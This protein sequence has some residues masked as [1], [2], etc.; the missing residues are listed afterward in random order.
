MTVYTTAFYW[1]VTYFF[2]ALGIFAI[3]LGTAF[4]TWTGCLFA[5]TQTYSPLQEDEEELGQSGQSVHGGKRGHRATSKHHKQGRGEDAASMVTISLTEDEEDEEEERHPAESEKDQVCLIFFAA[6]LCTYAVANKTTVLHE[7]GFKV[8]CSA[9]DPVLFFSNSLF[10]VLGLYIFGAYTFP[11]LYIPTMEQLHQRSERYYALHLKSSE[12]LYL[13]I[14]I[15]ASFIGLVVI[16]LVGRKDQVPRQCT[17]GGMIQSD[18]TFALYIALILGCG[19]GAIYVVW[20]IISLWQQQ[21][22]QT[23]SPVQADLLHLLDNHY[24]SIWIALSVN[25]VFFLGLITIF[26]IESVRYAM[27][28]L[29][30][31]TLSAHFPTPEILSYIQDGI[32]LGWLFYHG[33]IYFK[34]LLFEVQAWKRHHANDVIVLDLKTLNLITGRALLVWLLKQDTKKPLVAHKPRTT[35]RAEEKDSPAEEETQLVKQAGNMHE[36]ADE[37][38]AKEEHVDAQANAQAYQGGFVGF[39]HLILGGPG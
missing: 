20:L 28:F 30:N 22:E 34:G 10:V 23:E 1:V 39:C 12:F 17:D 21:Q 15:S 6:A 36:D 16:S 38:A 2:V 18:V 25:L 7:A 11:L 4:L 8:E 24:L 3:F 14:V 33:I 9:Y 13:A 19:I 5:Q 27:V 31:L 35:T 29:S 26:I 37:E 32:L